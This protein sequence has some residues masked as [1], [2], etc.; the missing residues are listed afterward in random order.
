MGSKIFG[1][2]RVMQWPVYMSAEKLTEENL[3]FEKKTKGGLENENFFFDFLFFG[4]FWVPLDWTP[5]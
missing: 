2:I 4:G 1:N 5:L 3:T